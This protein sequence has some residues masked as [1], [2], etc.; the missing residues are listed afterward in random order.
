MLAGFAMGG[1][2]KSAI[3]TGSHGN[4]DSDANSNANSNALMQSGIGPID[5]AAKLPC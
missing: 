4:A 5:Q 1:D 2:F 3:I